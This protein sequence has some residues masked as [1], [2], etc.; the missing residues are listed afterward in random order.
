MPAL[1]LAL[2]AAVY[3]S[4][5]FV[6]FP[7]GVEIGAM[8][9]VAVDSNDRVYVLHRGP[10]PLLAFDRNGKFLR[11]WGEG[12]F[13]VAHG[14]RIDRQGNVWTTDN[15]NHLL[16]KFSPEGKLLQTIGDLFKAPDDLVFASDGS[17]FVADS[18]NGRIAKITPE[19]KPITA[20]GK[21]GKG[22]GEFATTHA[23]A[24][25]KL[26]R[27]YVADR[28]NR[29]IEV[30]APDGKFIAAW[31]GF[32]NPFGAIVIGDELLVSDGEAHTISHLSLKDGR[33]AG[34]W[35][36]PEMLKLPH[37]MAED[38]RRRLYVAEVNG[39][40]VQIFRPAGSK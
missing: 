3:V 27:V 7:P 33:M 5:G 18:G 38:S 36:N 28:N 35:G 34:Q 26:D 19:G 20:W 15:G 24:I 11:A 9:A 39:K 25:D 13:K 32:G 16:R 21:K 17:I 22:D 4:V 1:T 31:T 40:R 2:A 8:S 12:L 23:L 10:Q 14:L 29:R 30:F 37:L 6:E